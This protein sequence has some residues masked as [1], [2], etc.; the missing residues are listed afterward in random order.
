M[1][2]ILTRGEDQDTNIYWRKN[3]WRHGEEMVIRKP[4]SEI[5]EETN[6]VDIFILSYYF[7]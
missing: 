3:L 5:S 4:K 1:T 7:P 2:D 6:P